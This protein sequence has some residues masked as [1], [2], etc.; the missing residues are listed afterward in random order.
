MGLIYRLDFPNGKYY[1]GKTS[2]SLKTR[3]YEH[4]YN[5]S[6]GRD[7]NLAVYNAIRKYGYETI[8]STTLCDNIYDHDLLNALEIE[9]IA[10]YK[11][12]GKKL[13]NLT[14]GGEGLSQGFKHTAEA[15]IAIGVASTGRKRSIY[16][17]LKTA[18]IMSKLTTKEVCQI[19]ELF[20]LGLNCKQIQ[21]YYPK[22]KQ[23][24]IWHIKAGNTWKHIKR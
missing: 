23:N 7:K 16:G 22:V 6:S 2:G 5:A 24:T 8:T 10:E 4:K 17:R 19:L 13:Y 14:A 11:Q 15:K 3:L 21:H 12:H 1:I 20:K 18:E 9:F